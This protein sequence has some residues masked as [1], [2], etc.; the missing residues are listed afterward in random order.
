MLSLETWVKHIVFLLCY[1]ILKLFATYVQKI[2]FP[3]KENKCQSAT[4]NVFM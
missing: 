1:Q 4:Y 3:S 2:R